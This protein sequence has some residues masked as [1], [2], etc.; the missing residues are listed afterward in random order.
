MTLDHKKWER[1]NTKSTDLSVEISY[2][3]LLRNLRWSQ[4]FGLNFV[5]CSPIGA[6]ELIQRL[7]RDVLPKP[8]Q[9]LRLDQPIDNLF[10]IIRDLPDLERIEI[11]FIIGLEKSLQ[12]D[13]D[14]KGFGGQGGYYNLSSV[15]P[16]L[17]HLNWQRDNFKNYFGHINFVFLLPYF[18]I[19]YLMRRAPDFVDWGSGLTKYPTAPQ[20]VERRHNELLQNAD[21][22]FYKSLTSEAREQ[23]FWELQ[24]QQDE[25]YLE[26]ERKAEICHRQGILRLADGA[27]HKALECFQEAISLRPDYALAYND[28]GVAKSNLGDQEEAIADYNQAIDL[29]P[30]YANAYNNRGNAKSDLGDKQGAIN[31]YSQAILLKPDYATAYY[32][33]GC[34]KFSL[35]DLAGAINDYKQ[36]LFFQPDFTDA[37]HNLSIADLTVDRNV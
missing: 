27:M 9:V 21:Y 17:A 1:G 37:Q 3:A 23:R 33:R 12:S 16:I 32:N 24:T 14:P 26:P 4:G 35:G 15:P 34:A 8:A 18:G 36:A 29:S 19:K 7:T 11:L 13:I 30:D 2:R 31:D 5:E 10:K 22:K 25:A 20:I 28:R 6:E